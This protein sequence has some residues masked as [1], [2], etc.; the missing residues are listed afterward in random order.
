MK[1]IVLSLITVSLIVLPVIT[2]A[3]IGG[4]VPTINL[5][6]QQLGEKIANATW[7]VFTI[8]ALVMFVVAGIMFITAQGDPEKIKTAR[9]AFIWGVAGI[10]VAIIAFTIITVVNSILQ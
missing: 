4:N 8:I 6:L 7:I 2:L 10:V 1:K 3:Q 9:G 5:S